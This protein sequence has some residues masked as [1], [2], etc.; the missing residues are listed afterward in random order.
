MS[1][2]KKTSLSFLL[3]LLYLFSFT[4]VFADGT[5]SSLGTATST[6]A[7]SDAVTWSQGYPIA[8]DNYGNYMA[9]VST[10]GGSFHMAVSNNKG[11]TWTELNMASIV[12]RPAFAYDSIHDK[13]HVLVD[14]D[15][16]IKYRRYTIQRNSSYG[17]TG[18]TLDSTLTALNL[19]SQGGCSAYTTDTHYPILL[20]KNTGTHGTL[21]AFWSVRKTCS[22]SSVT[23]VRASMRALSNS[24]ADGVAGNWAA[25]NGSS[26][27]S[28]AVGPALVAYNKLYGYNG[29]ATRA[30]VPAAMI[31]G[32]SGS[33]KDDIYLFNNDENMTTGFRRLGWSSGSSNWSGTWTSRVTFGGDLT[34]GSGYGNKDELITKPVYDSAANRVYI[35]IARY[36]S[37]GLGDTQSLFYVDSSDAVSSGVNV[38][39]ANGAAWFAP[40]LDI[41]YNSDDQKVYIFYETTS[42]TDGH[43]DYKTYSGSTLSSATNFFTASGLSVDIPIVYQVPDNNRL[44]LFFRVDGTHSETPS[45]P[46]HAIYSGYISSGGTN[47]TPTP[48]PLASTPFTATTYADFDQDCAV[49]SST[50]IISGSGGEVALGSS[51]RDD[52]E[53]PRTP[54]AYLFSNLWS[55]GDFDADANTLY[56]P[57]PSGGTLVL[58][59]ANGAFILGATGFTQKTLEFRAKF[60][61]HNFQH[62]GF[63]DDEGFNTFIMFSTASNGT[64][65]HLFARNTSSGNVDLGTG[66]LDAFHTYKIVWTNSATTFFIDG[67]QVD[68]RADSIGTSLKP[69]ASNNTNTGGSLLELD[70]LNVV[71]Y[72]TT[73]G[74]T[75]QSCG[76]NSGTANTTWGTITFGTTLNGGTATVQTRTSN[77]H[78][79]W[80]S[81][82]AVTSGNSSASPVGKFMQY[83]VTLGGSSTTT[84][85]FNNIS[86]AFASPTPSPTNTPTPTST[87]APSA[88]PTTAPASSPTP[89][90]SVLGSSTS[91][92]VSNGPSADATSQTSNVFLT[93]IGSLQTL[94]ISS[95]DSSSAPSSPLKVPEQR[96]TFAGIADSG[97]YVVINVN[98]G[99]Y[100]G[101]VKVADTSHWS[102]VPDYP[103]EYGEYT[104]AVRVEDEGKIRRLPDFKIT[105]S[106]ALSLNISNTRA[107]GADNQ[108]LKANT[109]TKS[110]IPKKNSVPSD[111]KN[112][113]VP[114]QTKEL[115]V[116]VK[117]KKGKPVVDANVTLYSE[118]K[119]SKTDVNGVATFTDV[120]AGQHTLVVD[121]NGNTGTQKIVV[122]SDPQIKRIEISV[123]VE[124]SITSSTSITMFLL[125]GLLVVVILFIWK[126][127]RD[128]IK[129]Y[130]RKNN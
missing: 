35:G 36:L 48:T 98:P 91:S 52:F 103:L 125:G 99:G 40:T 1:F 30:F 42:A 8:I 105:I 34:N 68:T 69:I 29:N 65:G 114:N 17:I 127:W 79:T 76:L 80:S 108:E 70:W 51:F 104:V 71:N 44:F 20:W 3:I 129:P 86:V 102:W 38:Y 16:T 31:Q 130:R 75:Y 61:S 21:V 109:E 32:G 4:P 97:V 47:T 10:T 88:T 107:F 87:P 60:T 101:R 26:D 55:S 83:L 122:D 84:P 93:Q 119:H 85:T 62:I 41:A 39:S 14:D 111:T 57:L 59:N 18:F 115:K 113:T 56:S 43:V 94:F 82:S 24:S 110:E 100:Q 15:A 11:G 25:L 90:G 123:T 116:Q 19:D 45:S 22:G 120:P 12:L 73:S 117:D 77:D 92:S 96:P 2:I 28:G 89:T 128:D 54:Y 72:P 27:S 37:G 118:P 50:Q 23:E 66:Y 5:Y 46:P 64:G 58:N 49:L 95:T 74:A 33:H 124:P 63:A 81:W 6:D 78:A 9:F 13:I 53:T 112:K 126:K 67:V 106:P 121:A 7:G